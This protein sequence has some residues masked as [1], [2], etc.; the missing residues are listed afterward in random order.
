MSIWTGESFF[1]GGVIGSELPMICLLL[2]VILILVFHISLRKKTQKLLQVNGERLE[3]VLEG[4]DLG[5]WDWDIPSKSL[6]FNDRLARMIGYSLEELEPHV[7]VMEKLIHPDDLGRVRSAM[8]AHLANEIPYYEMEYRLKTKSG[9]TI[10]VLDR[11]KVVQRDEMGKPL[12]ASGTFMDITNRKTMEES[13]D[14]LDSQVQYAQKLES[15]G[16]LAGGIAHDFNNILMGILGNAD[17]ALEDLS[18]FSPVREYIDSIEKAAKR[19]ADLCRQMLAYSGKGKFVLNEVDLRELVHEMSHI[20]NVSISKKHLLKIHFP[21]TLPRIKA[22]PSQ[23]SQLLLNLVINASEA[24]G[25]QSGVISIVTGVMSCDRPYLRNSFLNEYLSEGDYVFVEVTDT[26]C[27]MDEST[28]SKLFDPFFSTKFIGRGLGLAAVL[29]IVRGH[30]GTLRVYSEI[31]MGTTIKILFPASEF[32]GHCELLPED[33]K[34]PCSLTLPRKTV[35]VVDDEDTVRHVGR[36]M[37]EKL[38]FEVMTAS[39]GRE[40]LEI[41]KDHGDQIACVLLDLTM[42]FMDGQECFREIRRIRQDVP[43][44]LSSGYNE[45]DA[46]QRFVG[47]GLAGFIQKPYVSETLKVKLLEVLAP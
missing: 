39:E 25:D 6:T 38:G 36:R 18:P 47:K 7:Q 34:V 29:G 14:K 41:F 1:W 23:I 2:L 43:V 40:A 21:Q 10:W 37:L 4:A 32:Q 20:L 44:I 28:K 9:T 15:L 8:K 27:G 24:I 46:T 31:G 33:K 17:L 11:G 3:L 5:M 45:Q 13:R 30:K 12:R 16:V 19:A 22:D 35:L 26:G 42:P